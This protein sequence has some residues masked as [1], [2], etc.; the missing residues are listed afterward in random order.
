MVNR[1]EVFLKVTDWSS[2]YPSVNRLLAHLAR[3]SRSRASRSLYCENLYA[4]CVKTGKTPDEL[5]QMDKA[6]L[7]NC[8]QDFCDDRFKRTQNPAST[9]T[10]LEILKT[11]FRR[12]GFANDRKLDVEGY[13]RRGYSRKRP[14]YV[15][16]LREATRMGSFAG[17]LRNGAIVLVLMCTGLRNSTLRA[18]RYSEVKEELE[19][20]LE[21]IHIKVHKG[22]KEIVPDACKNGIEYSVFTC[23]EATEAL[24]LYI[25]ERIRKYGAID[26]HEP[27][28]ISEPARLRRCKRVRKPLTS[29]EI[30]LIVKGAA[31]RAGVDKWMNVRPHCLRKTFESVLRSPQIDG[32]RMDLKTQE[33][34]MGH[35]LAGSMDAYYDRSKIEDL[36]KE[37][38]KLVFAPYDIMT[39]IENLKAVAEA[40]GLDLAKLISP[41][42]KGSENIASE[43]MRLLQSSLQKL[44]Q[45]KDV[46]NDLNSTF[47]KRQERQ[48]SG[49]E[50]LP[51]KTSEPPWLKQA[52]PT[53]LAFYLSR[54]YQLQ[55]STTV[56]KNPL[57]SACQSQTTRK[58]P[59]LNSA[60][61]KESKQT[62]L[63][64]FSK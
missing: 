46:R 12:N 51:M 26:E 55:E 28:F 17:N 19:G 44:M 10:T 32:G 47:V 29:R 31:L 43:T 23:P 48:D 45:D 35:R 14:E 36:R 58:D 41:E 33:V 57:S 56:Q 9:T 5:V 38:A 64:M 63:N 42:G 2:E 3:L 18:I 59:E 62:E 37:Y 39:L 30:Q 8:L 16:T 15:P 20:G 24:G 13:S 4:F 54:E 27:L 60:R 6:E 22:M 11:F 61:Q 21:R 52:K 49:G 1:W 25:K 50:T 53:E 40:S 7:E 34:F